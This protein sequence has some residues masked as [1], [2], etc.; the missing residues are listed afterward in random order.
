[1]SRFLFTKESVILATQA[2]QVFYLDDPKN[3]SNWKVIQVVKNKRTQDVPEV[4]DVENL[5]LNVLEIIVSHQVDEHIEDDTLCRTD[6]DP[7]IVERLIVCYVADDFM[8]NGVE[9]LS[10]Q[11]GTNDDE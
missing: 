3:G 10:H 7:T 1:M 8:D 4:N 6:V 5:Q 2:H 9:Q 11:S